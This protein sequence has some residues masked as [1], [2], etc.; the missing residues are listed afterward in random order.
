VRNGV[1]SAYPVASPRLCTFR[2]IN[3]EELHL[4]SSVVESMVKRDSR[5]FEENTRR[6]AGL[7]DKF[8]TTDQDHLVG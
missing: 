3:L 4:T 5:D 6:M 7:M 8:W 2:E 1:E